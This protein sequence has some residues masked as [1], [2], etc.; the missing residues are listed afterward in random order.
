ME[1]PAV[2]GVFL[3]FGP[4]LNLGGFDGL[5]P[6]GAPSFLEVASVGGLPLSTVG[7]PDWF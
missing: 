1:F 7:S 3:K 5:F 4:L 6:E 2:L